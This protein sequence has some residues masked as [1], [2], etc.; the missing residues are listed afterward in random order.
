[1]IEPTVVESTEI[2]STA[3]GDAAL[4]RSVT[5]QLF[6]AFRD[7]DSRPR[8]ELRVPNDARVEDL[9][10]ALARFGEA[11]WGSRF[12]PALL[13]ASAFASSREILRDGSPLPAGETDFAVLPPVSGG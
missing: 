11:Q 12:R 2:G 5:V 10:R 1:M 6:G 4:G 7:C 9:R 8:I 3:I 13:A